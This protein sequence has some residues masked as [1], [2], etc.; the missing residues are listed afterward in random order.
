MMIFKNGMGYPPL[1]REIPDPP[2]AFHIRGTMP[3]GTRSPFAIVGTRRATPLGLAT[4]RLFGRELALAGFPI[5]S[6]LALGI[7]AAAHEG[8]LDAPNGLAIAVLA[9]GL[10]KIYPNE[11]AKL[12]ERILERGGAIISEYPESTP[13]YKEHFLRRNRIVS[14]LSCGVLIVEA[15]ENS[16]SLA[17]ARHAMEQNRDL[18]VVPGPVTH[19]NFK[20]SHQLIRQG[21]TLVTTPEEILEEYGVT[22]EE[23]IAKKI[24]ASS[25]EEK[26]VLYALRELRAPAEVDKIISM[27]KLEPRVV[28]RTITFLLLRGLVKE[29]RGGYT[30]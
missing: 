1:L 26:Q 22:R 30:I 4:A 2:P 29:G 16:G 23:K 10:A 25:D 9:G 28:T 27:T 15:P 24:E 21:A 19:G 3:R 17:T 11:N 12:G 20:G 14:G 7:D 13:P 8:C 5:V 18:F 6:G